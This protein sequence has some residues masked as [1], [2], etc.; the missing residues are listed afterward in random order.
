MATVEDSTHLRLW[1]VRD[2]AH[3]RKA[4]RAEDGA[5]VTSAGCLHAARLLITENVAEEVSPWDLTDLDRPRELSGLPAAAGGYYPV[6]KD[7]LMTVLSDGTAQFWDVRN[8]RRPE[9]TRT[10][11]FD[12][13]IESVALSPD[14]DR[15]VTSS[16]YRIWGTGADGQWQTPGLATLAAA[17]QVELFPGKRPLMAVVPENKI[18]DNG[19][20][21]YLLGLDTD[22]TY[23]E[24]CRTH[25]LSVDKVQWES[26]FPHL[27]HR[28][29]CD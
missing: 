13:P 29:S 6:G 20:Q 14:G 2:P 18:L 21:T 11:R 23:D 1:D 25:P 3:P 27:G 22:S 10:L 16:P 8:P 24:L 17:R 19:D 4:A 28:R 26:L 5:L 9:R 12:R 7:A 15:A